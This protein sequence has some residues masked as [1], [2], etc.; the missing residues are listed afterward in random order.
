MTPT[1]VICGAGIGKYPVIQVAGGRTVTFT[2]EPA[3]QAP[4]EYVMMT[5]VLAGSVGAEFRAADMAASFTYPL[6]V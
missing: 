6:S 5:C 4:A 2:V 1:P 3:E